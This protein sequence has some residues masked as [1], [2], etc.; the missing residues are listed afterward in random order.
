MNKEQYRVRLA[1]IHEIRDY[2]NGKGFLE[3]ETPVLASYA[4]P[5]STI[6]LFKTALVYA[7]RESFP[8]QLLPS[9]EYYMKQLLAAEWG[10]IFQFCRSFRNEEIASPLHS[11]EFVMLEYYW[12][13]HDY[14]HNMDLSAEMFGLLADKFMGVKL[15]FCRM[16]MAEAFQ[17][18]ADISLAELCGDGNTFHNAD[19]V[20]IQ[21]A[22][23]KHGLS[24]TVNDSWEALFN[25]LFLNL[26]EPEI[27]SGCAT[28]GQPVFLYDY[29]ARLQSLSRNKIGT[30]WT[31][32]WE[33]Y[34]EG[35]EIANC[36][37]EETGSHEID[38]FFH[39][40][41]QEMAVSDSPT[42]ADPNYAEKLKAMPPCSGVALG[43]DRLVMLLTG[44]HAIRD[45]ML[46]PL[47]V[48]S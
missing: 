25:R 15:E 34:W 8:V 39:H 47:S 6:S 36:F 3:V 45:V 7:G 38:R 33:L 5:E 14:M 24:Y 44:S 42:L 37:S 35:I 2:F 22:C 1:I 43:L 31:E 21:Q 40:E 16:S 19:T 18:Y 29:P 26:V 48:R 30:P 23:Q 10:S 13:D 12:V 32:R 46:F 20:K 11:P 17:R 27:S 28:N 4:I 9:P 41:S